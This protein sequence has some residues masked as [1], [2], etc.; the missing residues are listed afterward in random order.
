MFRNLSLPLDWMF[1]RGTRAERELAFATIVDPVV[2]IN[3]LLANHA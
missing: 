3:Q 2:D 1:Q